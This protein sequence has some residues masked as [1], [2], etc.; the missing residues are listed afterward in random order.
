MRLQVDSGPQPESNTYTH[1]L[2]LAHLLTRRQ[3][4][5]RTS[6][7]HTADCLIP[8]ATN[9]RSNPQSHHTTPH[10]IVECIDC[11]TDN[12]RQQHHSHHPKHSQYAYDP[13]HQYVP[14]SCPNPRR[15]R[16]RPF[17]SE[18]E[19]RCRTW[20]CNMNNLGGQHCNVSTAR[21]TPDSCCSVSSWN[22][23]DF[24]IPQAGF[25]PSKSATGQA[26]QVGC[27]LGRMWQLRDPTPCPPEETTATDP[28]MV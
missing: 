10:H 18:P 23:S 7:V 1:K 14:T 20:R 27:Q 2:M 12:T 8:L 21:S 9:G 4:P 3:I 19:T 25:S 5:T 11:R 6:T 28:F 24:C 15:S 17:L 22:R 13:K 16:P 26:I